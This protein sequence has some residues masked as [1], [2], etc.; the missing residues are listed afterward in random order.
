MNYFKLLINLQFNFFYIEG[1][2]EYFDV[3]VF[4]FFMVL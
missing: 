3:E 4:K 1:L 2:K